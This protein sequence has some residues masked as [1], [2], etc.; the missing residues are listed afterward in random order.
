[1]KLEIEQPN[2]IYGYNESGEITMA[3]WQKEP[4][5]TREG[6]GFSIPKRLWWNPIW[7][8]RQWL[9]ARKTIEFKEFWVK[10]YTIW[11]MSSWKYK[12]FKE[13]TK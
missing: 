2:A 10:F 9:L 8:I 13:E 5:K 12:S 6:F 1:M 4:I 7:R 3:Y 11:E